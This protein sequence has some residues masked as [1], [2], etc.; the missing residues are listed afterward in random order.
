M[1]FAGQPGLAP[2]R[3]QRA[4][5]VTDPGRRRMLLI[6]LLIVMAVFP[7]PFVLNAVAALVTAIVDPKQTEARF[8]VVITGH[9]LLS[10]PFDVLLYGIQ[11]A[12]PALVLYL[13]WRNGEGAASI[14]LTVD[15]P[16]L[17][18]DA[19][20]LLPVFAAAFFGPLG[21]LQVILA[22]AGV[23]GF[24]PSTTG[25]PHI[26]AVVA[27]VAG[28]QAGIV[29]EIV[30]LGYL[31]RRLEQLGLRSG[32]LIAVAVL[33]RVSYHLYY[34]AAVIAFI[35]WAAVSVILYRRFRRLWPFIVVHILWD[36]TVGLAAIFNTSVLLVAGLLLFPATIAF[37][38]AWWS[39]VEATT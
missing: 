25:V 6:E 39:S 8:P 34:G 19:A 5:V 31:V 33:V 38:S 10:L 1:T 29:E 13:L 20:L 36:V 3:P 27:L 18:G 7:L 17:K 21:V 15:R 30:V 11:L 4:R 37:T 32:P 16:R 14:G 9:E 24:N 26:Y 2:A 23:H 22:T 12:A 28:V 35:V